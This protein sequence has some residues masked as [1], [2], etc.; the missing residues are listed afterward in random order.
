[1]NGRFNVALGREKELHERVRLN[2]PAASVLVGM[3]LSTT[4]LVDD[5]TLREYLTFAA[6]LAANDEVDNSGY[7]RVTW[8]DAQLSAPT[9][10]NDE[11]TTT[12]T[13]ASKTVSTVLNDGDVWSK[14]VI[15]YDPDGAGGTDS[16]IIPLT[17]QD[18]R[19]SG[20]PVTPNGDDIIL[21][22]PNGW[23]TL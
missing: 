14:L 12:L 13:L 19:I 23:L 7:A 1:M 2:D 3:A 8:T 10:D 16:E 15:G 5:E 22:W 9:I 20:S 11:N 18:I 6:I 17:Y 4:G 21:A